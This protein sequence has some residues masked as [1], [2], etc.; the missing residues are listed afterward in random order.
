[1]ESTSVFL[2]FAIFADFWWK[3]ADDSITQGL[4]HVIDIFFWIFFRKGITVSLF[5]ISL[6]VTNFRE[7]GSFCPP[8]VSSPK[9]AYPE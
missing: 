3:D 2:I 6:C 5:I 7:R 9:K 1:M 8:S 4:C